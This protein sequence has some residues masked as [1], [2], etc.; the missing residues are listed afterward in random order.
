MPSIIEPEINPPMMPTTSKS[1]VSNGKLI[2]AAIIRGENKNLTGFICMVLRASICSEILM[3]PIS[4]AM[5][6]PALAVTI[7]A[8]KTGPNS[9]IKVKATAAPRAASEPTLTRE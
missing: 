5:D 4:A 6:E 7:I 9:E 1:A 3:I 2:T 8:V